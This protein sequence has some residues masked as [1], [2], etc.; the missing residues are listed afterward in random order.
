[1]APPPRGPALLR[2]VLLL[3]SLALAIQSWGGQALAAGRVALV[4][5]NSDYR[6]VAKLDNPAN[7]AKLMRRPSAPSAS[8]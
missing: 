7:D 6:S 1:M 4:I 2:I 5:G 3:A 8:R